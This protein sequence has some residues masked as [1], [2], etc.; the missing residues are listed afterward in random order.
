MRRVA[1]LIERCPGSP[2]RLREGGTVLIHAAAGGVGS[3]A[4]RIART[5]GA[6]RDGSVPAADVVEVHRRQEAGRTH[7]KTGLAFAGQGHETG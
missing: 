7:G 3:A 4:A 5:L 2:G 6:S 1:P